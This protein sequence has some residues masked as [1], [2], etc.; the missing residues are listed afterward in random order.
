MGKLGNTPV[1]TK[2]KIHFLWITLF[3]G[4][5]TYIV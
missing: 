2:R 4:K 5:P 3:A 1:P